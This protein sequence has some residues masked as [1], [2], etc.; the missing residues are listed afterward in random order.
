MNLL[1]RHRRSQRGGGGK[2]PAL[3]PN[4]IPP[5]IKMITTKPYVY[6]IFLAFPRMQ[7]YMSAT[8]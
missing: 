5:M 2:N 4:E 6:S 7:Q 8:D 3:L 1:L